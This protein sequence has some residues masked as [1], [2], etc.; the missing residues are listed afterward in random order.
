MTWAARGVLALVLAVTFAPSLAAAETCAEE[1]ALLRAHL[2]VEEGRARRWNTAW[3]I[4]YGTVSAAQFGLALA[5]YKPFGTYDLAWRDTLLVGG[6][7][8]ALGL[9]VRLVL[10]LKVRTLAASSG[11]PCADLAA[12][13]ELLADAGRRERRSFWFNH[14]GGLAVNLAG[15]LLLWREHDLTTASLSFGSGVVAGILAAYTQPRRSWHLWRDRR[16]TW[17]ATGG[18][19]DGGFAVGLAGS[20]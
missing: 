16:A 15:A 18:P 9:G 11:D 7:K 5:E 19:T 3:A 13:R 10:P 2:D 14:L 20:W 17:T 8:A 4:S 6:S 12:L 1:V